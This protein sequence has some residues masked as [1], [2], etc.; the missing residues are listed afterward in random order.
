MKMVDRER[1]TS[2]RK[3][4][5]SQRDTGLRSLSLSLVTEGLTT[6]LAA[7]CFLPTDDP[8][9]HT[10]THTQLQICPTA[11][12]HVDAQQPKSF[13]HVHDNQKQK[14]SSYE[15]HRVRDILTRKKINHSI[16]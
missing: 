9:T 15:R 8:D 16:D 7:Y 6:S 4:T 2:N 14:G 11:V 1:K 10:D 13:L 5:K 3:K 12:G